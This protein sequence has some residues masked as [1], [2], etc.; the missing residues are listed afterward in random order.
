MFIGRIG[1]FFET[2]VL[3]DPFSPEPAL[4]FTLA[5]GEAEALH[6]ALG[7]IIN[8]LVNYGAIVPVGDLDE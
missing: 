3:G 5:S 7:H 6:P 4:S 2:N 8:A 1:T